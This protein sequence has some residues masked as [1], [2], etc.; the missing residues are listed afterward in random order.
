MLEDISD[1]KE[2]LMV[3][4]NWVEE[5]ARELLGAKTRVKTIL[6]GAVKSVIMG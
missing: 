2:N 4:L 5:K 1:N 6:D 3:A